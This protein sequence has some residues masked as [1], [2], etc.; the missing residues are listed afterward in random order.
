MSAPVVINE[1]KLN[2]ESILTEAKSRLTNASGALTPMKML[3]GLAVGAL[4]VTAMALP[5]ATVFSGGPSQPLVS[6]QIVL[7]GG[8]T[9]FE[10]PYVNPVRS[11]SDLGVGITDFEEPC[12]N[13]VRSSSDLGVGITDFEEPCVTPV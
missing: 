10:E 6:E 11:S 5:L 3:A 8:I 2:L 1:T 9:D 7:G 4:L 12:V 13:P